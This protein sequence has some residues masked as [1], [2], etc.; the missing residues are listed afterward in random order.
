MLRRRVNVNGNGT[1]STT[2]TTCLANDTGTWRWQVDYSGD[3]NNKPA[4]SACGVENF[5]ITNS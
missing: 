1:Y 5:T 4:T 3:G 2:N